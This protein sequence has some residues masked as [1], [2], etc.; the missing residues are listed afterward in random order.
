MNDVLSPVR[1]RGG[2]AVAVALLS[3]CLAAAS[4]ASAAP[5]YADSVAA[6]FTTAQPDWRPGQSAQSATVA[7][8]F[9]R[10]GNLVLVQRGSGKPLWASGTRD[11]GVVRLVW[12]STGFIRLKNAAG[13]DVC[14]IGKT[15]PAAG[16]HASV[17]DDGNLVFYKPNGVPSWASDTDGLKQ[18]TTNY[19]FG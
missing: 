4:S 6:R 13:N 10:D 9:Q 1:R 2:T 17:Q 19:C 11:R 12:T 8:V 5:A 7:L 3:A 16:G 15:R 14:T 18:G